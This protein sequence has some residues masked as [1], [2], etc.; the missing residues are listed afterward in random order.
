M[1]TVVD[2]IPLL[3]G[4][5]LPPGEDLQGALL[6]A[7]GMVGTAFVYQYQGVEGW[8]ASK[9]IPYVRKFFKVSHSQI[10]ACLQPS[11]EY[12]S[13]YLL[14]SIVDNQIQMKELDP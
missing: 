4:A 1:T 2:L 10:F 5:E 12:Y 7:H 6:R 13:E 9:C 3:R 8:H 11:R 14:G